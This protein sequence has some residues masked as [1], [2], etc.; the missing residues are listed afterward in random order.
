MQPVRRNTMEEWLRFTHTHMPPPGT[1]C[2]IIG[3]RATN[4]YMQVTK[5][6]YKGYIFA[7][8]LVYNEECYNALP[9]PT[10]T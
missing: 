5:G 4:A 2:E 6:P 1:K 7:A 10:A 8:E 3:V 9:K